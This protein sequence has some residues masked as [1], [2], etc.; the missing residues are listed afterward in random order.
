MLLKFAFA[1]EN[2]EQN[3][4]TAVVQ[5]YL[6]ALRNPLGEVAAEPVVRALLERSVKRIQ[7]LCEVMLFRSYPRLRRAPMNLDTDDV[8]SV[9]VERLIKALREARPKTVREFY[10]LANQHMRWELNDLVRR[11]DRHVQLLEAADEIVQAPSNDDSPISLTAQRM[12]AAIEGLPADLRETFSLV[13]MHG[14]SQV[15]AAGV[16]GVST[17]TVQ[18]R[19]SRSLMMLEEQLV[20][21]QPKN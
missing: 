8:L 21:L 17:K 10:A 4:T 5:G 13:R 1:R 15:E 19:L 12:L 20:D 7:Q 3:D 14:V 9:V 2:M 16:L 6:D 11:L 18:R